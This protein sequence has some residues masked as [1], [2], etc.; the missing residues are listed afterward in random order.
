MLIPRT[1]KLVNRTWR[2]KIVSRRVMCREAHE[3]AMPEPSIDEAPRG[4]CDPYQAVIYLRKDQTPDDLM[5]TF[6]HEV[7][8]ALLFATGAFSTKMHPEPLVDQFGALMAQLWT[9]CKGSH[10]V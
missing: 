2:V 9:T 7:G 10:E 1:F 8:H 5:H 4:L 6:W 3:D